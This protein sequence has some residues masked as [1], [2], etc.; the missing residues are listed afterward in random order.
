M[1]H[2]AAVILGICLLLG[3]AHPSFVF[4]E[5]TIKNPANFGAGLS[6]LKSVA[7]ENKL[8]TQKT[9]TKEIL[10]TIVKWLL[11]FTGIIATIS[12]LYGGFLYITSQGEENKAEQAKN[13]ILYSVI[14]IIIIGISAIVVNVVINIATT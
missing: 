6:S 9:S 14:G 5:G 12:L 4:A 13:I 10:Q 1:K 11:S 2:T 7:E 8:T 3:I